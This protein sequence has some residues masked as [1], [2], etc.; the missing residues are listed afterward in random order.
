MT[1]FLILICGRAFAIDPP[2]T[3]NTSDFATDNCLR[4]HNSAQFSI[5]AQVGTSI[6]NTTTNLR[7]RSCH[8]T[9]VINAMVH[10]SLATSDKYGQWSM[11]CTVCH[12]PHY[13][14]QFRT[15]KAETYLDT[16][17][18]SAR[19]TTTITVSGKNWATNQW[20]GFNVI[21]NTRYVM[22]YRISSNT[23]NTLTLQGT[24]PTKYFPVGSTMAIYYGKLMR[25]QIN[26]GKLIN[27]TYVKQ[28][29]LFNSTGPNSMATSSMHLNDK[30]VCVTCHTK[31]TSLNIEDIYN[32]SAASESEKQH[33]IGD[34]ST[35][36]YNTDSCHKKHGQ[37]FKRAASVNCGD[38]HGNPPLSNTPSA[39]GTVFKTKYGG[40]FV[41]NTT[42][43]LANNVSGAAH[44]KHA[45]VRNYTCQVCHYGGMYAPFAPPNDQIPDNLKQ[46]MSFNLAGDT[47]GFYYGRKNTDPNRTMWNGFSYNGSAILPGAVGNNTSYRCSNLYCHSSGNLYAVSNNVGGSMI[48]NNTTRWNSGIIGCNPCHSMPADG[49]RTW[50]TKHDKHAVVYNTNTYHTCNACHSTVASDNSTISTQ[51]NHVNRQK[52]IA[53]NSSINP[54]ALAYNKAL[55]QCSNLYCHSNANPLG[56]SN[57]YVVVDWKQTSTTNCTSCHRGGAA[58]SKPWSTA[59]TIHSTGGATNYSY[60]C[61]ECHGEVMANNSNSTLL[62][63]G[64]AKHIDN[65]KNVKFGT[66]LKST[67]LDQSGGGYTGVYGC[68]STYCHSKGI[69]KTAP[70]DAEITVATWDGTVNCGS[71]HQSKYSLTTGAHNKHLVSS[72]YDYACVRCHSSVVASDTSISAGGI[73]LH[74][75]AVNQVAWDSLNQGA[76]NYGGTA[77][78]TN[79]Y[80]HSKGTSGASPY[81]AA[82]VTAKWG[83]TSFPSSDCSGCHGGDAASATKI[84]TGHHTA[85]INNAGTLGANYKCDECHINTVSGNRAIGTIGQLANH[86]DKTVDIGFIAQN[87]TG[88]YNGVATPRSLPAGHGQAKVCS[89]LYCHSNGLATTSSMYNT[90]AVTW[91]GGAIGCNG[92][93]GRGNSVGMPD[94]GNQGETSTA[95][96]SHFSSSNSH[97]NATCSKCHYSTVN[98]NNSPL[99]TTT[100]HINVTNEVVFNGDGTWNQSAKTC[101]SAPSCHTSVSPKWGGVASGCVTCHK[102]STGTSGESLASAHGAHYNS[103]TAASDR[104]STNLSSANNYIFNCGVCHNVDRLPAKHNTDPDPDGGLASDGWKVNIVFNSTWFSAYNTSG[105]YSKG[106]GSTSSGNSGYTFW[107]NGTCSALY[108]HSS[109]QTFGGTPSFKSVAWNS[110]SMNCNSCHN[111]GDNG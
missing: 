93:H 74:V 101:D 77:G 106:D 2:H 34:T 104:A 53:F 24:M 40:A 36:Y 47:N 50:S 96:N 35:C 58:S 38:C 63:G 9:G 103:T 7:C 55:N 70:F 8:D 21:P 17:V 48:Y 51:A 78:C 68:T 108:C 30:G 80:C 95:P 109:G 62:S 15:Y 102:A 28:T 73:S 67:T 5:G 12:D 37:G 13:Q 66:T 27:G 111:S 85:H 86:V 82:T 60:T 1:T 4:C 65:A 84:T 43:P 94:Y 39:T 44:N 41:D 92:C 110:G 25:S 57:E 76:D 105:T 72:T 33:Y 107:K 10:S 49:T 98:A 71:C 11:G 59:H 3:P 32:G 14:F 6:D 42:G 89:N 97:N 64:Y 83:D 19:T 20:A 45:K 31:T 81:G 75:D 52:D 56:A 16:G 90:V 26:I 22:T 100:L 54:G 18:L 88:M 61:D 79:N 23:L 91:G 29:K 69:K 99:T 46:E 87:S